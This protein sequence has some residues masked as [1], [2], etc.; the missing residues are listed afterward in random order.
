M[1]GNVPDAPPLPTQLIDHVVVSVTVKNLSFGDGPVCG[2]PADEC[3]Y[4]YV[5]SLLCTDAGLLRS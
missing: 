5:Q 3:A 2:C 4:V 1:T